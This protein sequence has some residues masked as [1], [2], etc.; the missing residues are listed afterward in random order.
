MSLKIGDRL[1][2]VSDDQGIGSGGPAAQPAVSPGAGQGAPPAL[3]Q[4]DV[5]P[6]GLCDHGVRIIERRWR[7][8]PVRIHDGQDADPIFPTTL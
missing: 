4:V 2:P 1:G 8:R 7:F 5:N 3:H 6:H